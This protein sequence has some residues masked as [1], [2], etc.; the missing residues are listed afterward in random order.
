MKKLSYVIMLAF[1][2]Y[3]LQGCKHAQKGT[4][5]TADTLH[6]NAQNVP[7]RADTGMHGPPQMPDTTPK[8]Y[9]PHKAIVMKVNS[10]DAKF[11]QAAAEGNLTEV[12]LSVIA[13]QISTDQKIKAIADTLITGHNKINDELMA[14]AKTKNV[15]LPAFI[16]PDAEKNR[17]A[18]AKKSGKDFDKAFI[19]AMISGHKNALKLY[20]DAAKNCSDTDLKAFAA[21]T[22]PMIQMHLDAVSKFQPGN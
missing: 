10:A 19:S 3:I 13:L 14:I 9:V 12:A 16:P 4:N 6:Q 11:A 15:T 2:V 7:L 22:Q 21:K 5:Q 1:A 18:L 17:Q 20:Q 8:H